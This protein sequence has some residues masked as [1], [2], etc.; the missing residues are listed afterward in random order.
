VGGGKRRNSGRRNSNSAGR[1]KTLSGRRKSVGKGRSRVVIADDDP[2]VLDQLSSILKAHFDVVGRAE[3]G[4]ELC[5]AVSKLSPEVAVTDI[6][7]PEMNGIEATRL[8]AKDCPDVKIVVLS[9]HD[10]PE[11]IEAVFEAGASGYVSKFTAHTELI[12]AIEDVLQGRMYR[13][14][15]L[16]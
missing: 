13:S 5:K 15:R 2:I 11:I 16:V 12:P 3:N 7:M 1:A 4:R 6:A 10:E 9:I 14:R 8:I